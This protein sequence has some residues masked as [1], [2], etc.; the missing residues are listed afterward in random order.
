MRIAPAA[1][2][3]TDDRLDRV[4]LLPQH[5]RLGVDDA[6]RAIG[7]AEGLV[8]DEA[9]PAVAG[10]VVCEV[11]G[12]LYP[13]RT[14]PVVAHRVVAGASVPSR[15]RSAQAVLARERDGRDLLEWEAVL[16]PLDADVL[17]RLGVCTV[18]ESNSTLTHRGRR[19]SGRRTSSCESGSHRVAQ[20][21]R[22][23]G[24]RGSRRAWWRGCCCA[25]QHA[26]QIMPHIGSVGLTRQ[27]ARS[28]CACDFG[29]RPYLAVVISCACDMSNTPT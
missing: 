5:A 8:L 25:G 13:R 17:D 29:N 24:L 1:G 19:A 10:H 12:V 3:R 4:H 14:V 28:F 27:S 16:W 11:R 7:R 18:S 2:R 22:H 26:L 23:H 15:R 21:T 9:V 6:A 20:R